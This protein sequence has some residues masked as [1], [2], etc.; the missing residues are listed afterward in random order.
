MNSECREVERA[1]RLPLTRHVEE[2][3]PSSRISVTCTSPIPM[4]GSDLAQ[5]QLERAHRRGDQQLQ[6]AALALA[7]DRHR[8]EHHHGHGQDHADQAGHDVAPRC[9]APGCRRCARSSGGACGAAG[10]S[11]ASAA[12]SAE[13]PRAD[14]GDH[15]VG[16]RRRAAARGRSSALDAG[17]A[18]TRADVDADAGLAG[19]ACARSQV[20]DIAARWATCVAR[21]LRR[22][23]HRRDSTRD[24]L[25]S[26][27]STTRGRDMAHVVVDRVAE[28]QQ[29]HQR[30]ADDHA[31]GG[32]SRAQLGQL[33]DR[34]APIGEHAPGSVRRWRA[35]AA[36]RG[37]RS[38]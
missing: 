13:R 32:R 28:Q 23:E 36:R 3:V 2:Q 6:V 20:L 12:A 17:G 35:A 25:V 37:T 31:E 15:G 19:A 34:H 14:A 4:Y 24:R 22:L 10:A 5:H 21:T 7:H 30:D 1:A 8:G 9:A 18:R 38:R 16:C 29:L 11:R 33:L 27:S 26:A